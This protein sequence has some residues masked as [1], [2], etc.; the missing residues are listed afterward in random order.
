MHRATALLLDEGRVPAALAL[1]F[2]PWL[3]SASPADSLAVLK[4]LPRA[5]LTSRQLQGYCNNV[6][7]C[8]KEEAGLYDMVLPVS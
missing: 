3:L 6:F 5:L 1:R 2:L 4:V 7:V 8:C